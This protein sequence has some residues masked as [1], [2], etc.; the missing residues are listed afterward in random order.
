MAGADMGCLPHSAPCKVCYV[1]C[2][3]TLTRKGGESCGT[4][5]SG[6]AKGRS[7][8][9][10]RAHR[11]RPLVQDGGIGFLGMAAG[12]GRGFPEIILGLEPHPNGAM[13]MLLSVR[14]PGSAQRQSRSGYSPVRTRAWMLLVTTARSSRY[15]TPNQWHGVGSTLTRA[16]PSWIRALT[17]VGR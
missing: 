11:P 3:T 5:R 2:E 1:T 15:V 17:A 16:R 9:L 6:P 7:F 14:S 13:V 12:A 8:F 10:H 4:T